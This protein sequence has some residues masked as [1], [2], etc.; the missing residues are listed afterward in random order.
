M[1]SAV[2]GTSGYSY[3]DWRQVYYPVDLKDS[4]LLKF[5]S[6]E[7]K[8]I[9]IN[10]TYYRLLPA[11]S[12]HKMAVTTPEK[13]EFVVK[14]HQETT[15]RRKENDDV[16]PHLLESIKPLQEAEKL[17]GLLAQFPASFYNTEVNRRY[18]SAVRKSTGGGMPFFVE[19]RHKSWNKP[20]IETFLR[21]LDISYVNVDEP[22][23]EALLPAQELATSRIGYIRLHGRNGAMWW[24]GEGSQRYDYEYKPDELR[25]W[26]TRIGNILKK[27]YK[28]YIF[29]NNHPRGQ[30]IKNARE[31]LALL[32]KQS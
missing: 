12:F 3:P 18:I 6:R 17:V 29:F 10:A 30:A 22:P 14:T 24:Q 13:F 27:T 26:L 8:A 19:F 16:M 25:E 4:D 2:I 1:G 11:K 21:D 31:M 15:H 20:A 23:L 5:Y 32:E 7:F 9:E 28:T